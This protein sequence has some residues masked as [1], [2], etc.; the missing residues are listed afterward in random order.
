ML[1]VDLTAGIV[2]VAVLFAIFQYLKLTAGPARW[3]DSRRSYHLQL[4]REHLLATANEPEHPRD[5]RPQILAF[6]DDPQRRAQLL[7]FSSWIEGESGLTTAVRILEGKGVRMRKLK[8]EAEAELQH[9]I[10]KGNFS[11]FALVVVAHSMATGIQSIIQAYGVGALK[12]NTILLNW[13]GQSPNRILKLH[14]QEF[15]KNL[16]AARLY[17]SNLVILDA[18]PDKWTVLT[19]ANNNDLT[20]DVWWQDDATGHLMLL[21]AYLMTRSELWSDARIRLL[22][23]NSGHPG[24]HTVESLIEMLEEVRIDAEPEIIENADADVIAEH[25]AD[26]TLVFLPFRLKDNHVVDPFGNPME[27]TLFL[28]PVVAMVLAAKDIELAAEPEEGEAG[29]KA[30]VMDLLEAAQKKEKET[31]KEAEEA[32][33]AA[34]KARK[35]AEEIKSDAEAVD[36]KAVEQA[37]KNAEEAEKQADKLARKAA[38]AAAKAETAAKEA[39]DAGVLRKKPEEE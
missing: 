31:A 32:A 9:D 11:A 4:A 13:L 7:R 29:E 30:Q 10:Q 16:R 28:L 24:N 34:K 37:E 19:E 6:S 3:A 20:I 23:I 26:S 15:A 33:E 8:Q 14:D 27:D 2:A 36:A 38:K 18:K 17:E 35:K 1:A 22:A 25:S 39:E 21:M 12:A 5:W